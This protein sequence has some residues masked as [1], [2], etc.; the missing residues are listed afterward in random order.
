MRKICIFTGTRAEYGLLR[1][2]MQGIQDAP[3]L[4]LQIVATGMHLSP[5]FGLTIQEIR[6]DGFDPDET[7]EMLLVAIPPQP[8]VNPWASLI[9][10][11]EALQRLNPDI[12][13][14]GVY[15]QV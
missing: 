13:R 8:F 1:W 15:Q 14:Q 11:E 4:T 2:V 3:D 6:A 7:V 9:D 12:H 10:Y 5:E